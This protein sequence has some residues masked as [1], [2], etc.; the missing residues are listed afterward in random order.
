MNLHEAIQICKSLYPL[1]NQLGKERQWVLTQIIFRLGATTLASMRT[2][3]DAINKKDWQLASRIVAAIPMDKDE[4]LF[5]SQTMRD[6]KQPN[7]KPIAAAY[8][9][10]KNALGA[11]P[12]PAPFPD[13]QAFMKKD[14]AEA[15]N[16]P[17]KLLN[18]PL[19]NKKRKGKQK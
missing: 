13:H 7:V 8:S 14:V 9:D 4:A 5:L 10:F 19:S 6:N 3:F 16:V 11:E 17:E 18:I 1:F 12:E 15:F 2:L